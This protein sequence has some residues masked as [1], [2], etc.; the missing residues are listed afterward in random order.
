MCV[1]QLNDTVPHCAA[2]CTTCDLLLIETQTGTHLLIVQSSSDYRTSLVLFMYYCLLG[3]TSDG[4][5][6]V[7]RDVIT[8]RRRALSTPSRDFMTR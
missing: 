5:H 3:P 2:R 4:R 6:Y 7:R 1:V 8:V